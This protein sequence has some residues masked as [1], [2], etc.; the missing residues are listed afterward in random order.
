MIEKAGEA[1]SFPFW[2]FAIVMLIAATGFI[3]IPLKD[4]KPLFATP[5]A[6]TAL[7]VPLIAV[8]LYVL[9][10]SPAAVIAA[11]AQQQ[12]G[13]PGIASAANDQQARSQSSVAG[14]VDGLRNRL[15]NE[16]DDAGGWLLLAQSYEHL[17]RH[18]E[19]IAA[20]AH[21]QSLGKT[22]A[23]FEALLLGANA[24]TQVPAVESGSAIRG[25]VAL[26]ADFTARV[27]PEDT[28]F[29]FA[30]K[31]AQDRMPVVALRKT[32]ADL[33]FDFALTDKEV[34]VPGTRLADFEEL[35]VMARVSRN[36]SAADT[37]AGLEAWSQ[38]V[39]PANSRIIELT[40]GAASPSR[41]DNDE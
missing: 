18:D 14:L 8:G 34:M 20:Y 41:N 9:L 37:S 23:Q 27:R 17:G 15:E 13:T 21:A 29:I 31:S 24:T 40:I 2:V 35:L 38:P 26:S 7:L 33:P 12:R 5:I 19:A 10:G 36:G 16:P 22:D 30:K 28:V 25:R 4:G 11:S 39:S 32:V 6:L 1:M 3:A